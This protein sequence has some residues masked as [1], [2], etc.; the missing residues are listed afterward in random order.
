MKSSTNK[1]KSFTRWMRIIHR[2]LGFLMVGISLIYA[3]SGF[4]LN[5]MDGKDPAFK[6]TKET[7]SFEKGLTAEELTQLWAD[8]E[9][10]SLKK[11]MRIDDERSRLMLDG[12]MGIYH[13]AT[14]QA[15][16]EKHTRNDFIYWINKL[17]YNKVAGWTFMADIFAFALF[18]FAISGLLIVKGKKGL[19]GSGKWYLIAGLLIPILYLLFT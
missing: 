7:L 2:D 15:V 13:S 3:I 16:Y 19:R 4:I 18:F 6:V 1:S 17:H 12:G 8:K 14:G 9:L 5:H 11:V 10:P